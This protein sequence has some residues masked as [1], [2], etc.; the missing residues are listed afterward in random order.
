MFFFSLLFFFLLFDRNL[1][2]AAVNVNSRLFR[3]VSIVCL[4]PTCSSPCCCLHSLVWS[5]I[6]TFWPFLWPFL[7]FFHV[8]FFFTRNWGERVLCEGNRAVLP[9]WVL[10]LPRL[11]ASILPQRQGWGEI[12]VLLFCLLTFSWMVFVAQ[13]CMD[14]V[15][16]FCRYCCRFSVR[17]RILLKDACIAASMHISLLVLSWSSRGLMCGWSFCCSFLFLSFFLRLLLL[18]VVTSFW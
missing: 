17:C 16:W 12:H 5:T 7:F 10:L 3:R 4:F 18:S 13:P 9:S 15:S 2:T 8:Y 14:C 11:Q 6:I 1:D